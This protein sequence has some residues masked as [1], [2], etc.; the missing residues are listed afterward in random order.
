MIDLSPLRTL[1]P[2]ACRCRNRATP[3][4]FWMLGHDQ[5]RIVEIVGPEGSSEL[6]EAGSAV[7]NAELVDLISDRCPEPF[8][9]AR[10]CS[11]VLVFLIL[12]VFLVLCDMLDPGYRLVAV[13]TR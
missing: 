2:F 11:R 10:R 13:G 4:K 7:P 5:D 9:L 6:R 1:R 12:L 3:V 8:S